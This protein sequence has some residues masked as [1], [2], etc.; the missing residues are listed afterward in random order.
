MKTQALAGK[1]S[2]LA[3]VFYSTSEHRLRAGWRIMVTLFGFVAVLVGMAL[4]QGLLSNL[5]QTPALGQ[6]LSVLR[7]DVVMQSLA[8]TALIFL[9]RVWV[10]K[11]SIVSLGLALNRRTVV[12]LGFGLLLMGLSYTLIY[13]LMLEAGWL[14]ITRVAWTESAVITLLGGLLL[15]FLFKVLGSWWEELMFRGYVLQNIKDGLNV[16]WAV[17]LP[18]AFFGV[19]HLTAPNASLAGAVGVT[20]AG[21]L[22]G[23]AYVRT[24]QLWL[25]LGL[26]IG[27]NFFAGTVFGFAVS[28]VNQAESFHLVQTKVVGPE[29]ITGG[30]FGPEAGLIILPF[31]FLAAAGVYFYTRGRV[32][33]TSPHSPVA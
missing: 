17:I 7:L 27:G 9:A 20:V 11:R 10:D 8:I 33:A 16:L 1:R 28:G 25:P 14:Q 19:L 29:V 12:D 2:W 32:E 6:V 15:G 30:A 23:Y 21:L 5:S 24:R 4:F 26:H 22:L 3:G 31:L 18:A 13:F